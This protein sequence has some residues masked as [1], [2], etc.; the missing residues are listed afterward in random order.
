MKYH[1]SWL[2]SAINA[3]KNCYETQTLEGDMTIEEF[4]KAFQAKELK[5]VIKLD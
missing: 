2:E 5:K 3:F 1:I 4:I